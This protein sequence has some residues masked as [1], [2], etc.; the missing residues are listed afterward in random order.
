M[1]M[2]GKACTFTEQENSH[3]EMA[4]LLDHM[5]VG[6]AAEHRKQVLDRKYFDPADRWYCLWE[7]RNARY[8]SSNL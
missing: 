6:N 7:N 2:Q 5:H 3:R 8:P 4:T 1:I